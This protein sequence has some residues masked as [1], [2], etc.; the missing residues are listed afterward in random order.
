MGMKA[1]ATPDSWRSIS[2]MDGKSL[3]E[4]ILGSLSADDLIKALEWSPAQEVS[5]DKVE[6]MHGY[7][8]TWIQEATPETLFTFMRAVTGTRTL[9][10]S[11][12]PRISLDDT[13]QERLPVAQSCFF[14]L[15]MSANYSSQERFNE[16]MKEFLVN[17][18]DGTGFQRR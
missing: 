2:Q 6:E 3:A 8:R 5:P 13:E 4:R 15:D 9:V 7:M 14:R 11:R 17:A 1:Y 18:L 12:P 16:A 10:P